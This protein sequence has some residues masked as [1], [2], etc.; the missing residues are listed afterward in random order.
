VKPEKE[1]PLGVRREQDA[2]KPAVIA[3]YRS[4]SDEEIR[5]INSI[6]LTG[7]VIQE[8]CEGLLQ[9]DGG[10]VDKRAVNIAITNFQTAFMWANR[11]VAKPTT[12]A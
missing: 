12:F 11:A 3:G 2:P 5:L 6:K 9:I 4:L 7:A 8:M 10:F 1:E